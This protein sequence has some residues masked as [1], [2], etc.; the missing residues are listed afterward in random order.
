MLQQWIDLARSTGLQTQKSIPAS[1]EISE[2]LEEPT[3]ECD[4]TT[5]EESIDKLNNQ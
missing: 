3:V 1:K 4:T 2:A 5:E